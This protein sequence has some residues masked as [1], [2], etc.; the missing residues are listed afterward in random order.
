L[1]QGFSS[2]TLLSES[3]GAVWCEDEILREP[4][5]RPK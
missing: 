4:P 5:A 1:A 3:A 2:E